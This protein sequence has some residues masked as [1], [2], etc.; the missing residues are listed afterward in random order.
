MRCKSVLQKSEAALDFVGRS[1]TWAAE[2]VR[3]ESRGAGDKGEAMRRVARR[4]GIAFSRIWSLE[5]RPPKDV[6]VSVYQR[7][8]QAYLAMREDQIRRLQHEIEI[9]RAISG[10]GARAV[11][12]AEALVAAADLSASQNA[13]ASLDRG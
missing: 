10:D 1:R 12:A 4:I 8:A 6:P 11:R 3:A 13:L 7:L 2:L 5:Y 9:T